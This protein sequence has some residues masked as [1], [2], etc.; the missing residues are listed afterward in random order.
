MKFENTFSYRLGYTKFAGFAAL[1]ILII[2]VS[3]R[4]GGKTGFQKNK[5]TTICDSYQRKVSFVSNPQRIVSAAPGITEI[6]FALG[7]GRRMVGRTDFCDYPP[8]TKEIPSIGGLQDPNF[9]TIAGINP[10]LVIASTHF[11]REAVQK[12]ESLKI[13]VAVIMSEASF[14]GAYYTIS[15]I[16]RILDVT[17]KADSIISR[18]RTTVDSILT[19]VRT[20]KYKPTVYYVIG[21]GKTGDFTA[22]G[23]TFISKLIDMAGGV[24]IAG[25]ISGWSYSLEKLIEKDPDIILIRQGNKEIFCKTAS[26]SDLKAVK[27][28]HIYEINDDLFEIT[29]PRLAEGLK[30]LYSIIQNVE[31]GNRNRVH[32]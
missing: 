1:A 19:Q 32:R 12:L 28:G 26:Y 9:E 10:D 11:Q 13:P 2:S 20:E 5:D 24:N 21:F 25:D 27:T 4:S 8:E 3:C 14:D 15:R 17:H 22:G 23:N 31:P 7:E 29:G 30:C 6:I 18:M 16:G